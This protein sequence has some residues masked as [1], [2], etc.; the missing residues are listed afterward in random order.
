[1]SHKLCVVKT[2]IRGRIAS[3]DSIDVVKQLLAAITLSTWFVA[4]LQAIDLPPGEHPL[5]ETLVIG[6]TAGNRI[7]GKAASQMMNP[8]SRGRDATWLAWEGPEAGPI[9]RLLGSETVLEHFSIHGATW[10]AFK[11]GA[12]K[13]DVGLLIERPG[14][15]LPT[16][17]VKA[18][19]VNIAHAKVGLQVGVKPT[20]PQCAESEWRSI[21]FEGCPVAV[22]MIPAMAMGHYFSMVRANNCD[23]VFQ[24]EGGGKLLVD[25]LFTA[26]AD[27]T[28]VK[29][30]PVRGGV[31]HNNA[32][33]EF[34]HIFLDH[35]AATT[36]ICDM[37]DWNYGG[38]V[39]FN[40]GKI[41]YKGERRP[42]GSF[43]GYDGP[44]FKLGGAASVVIRDYEHLLPGMIQWSNSRF[45]TRVLVENSCILGTGL[46]LF[47]AA[48]STGNVRAILRDCYTGDGTPIPNATRVLTGGLQ[49]GFPLPGGNPPAKPPGPSSTP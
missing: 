33:Y 46:D 17:R 5:R 32:V 23:V 19:D 48:G 15:G 7:A 35:Q 3:G 44:A 47:D 45:T 40:R 42:D 16:G 28:L 29:L 43:S 31:G 14:V 38:S 10:N 21:W 4:P 13:P 37:A 9:V 49:S 2:V 18:Y 41:T 20:D 24:I 8:P 27:T 39:V 6:A 1:M 12:P 30:A 11:A 36:V 26:T 25:G 22:R 34:R